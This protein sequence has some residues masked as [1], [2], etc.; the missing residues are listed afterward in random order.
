M[1]L[2]HFLCMCPCSTSIRAAS[3]FHTRPKTLVVEDVSPRCRPTATEDA[4][5]PAQHWLPTAI[6]QTRTVTCSRPR[7]PLQSMPSS[8]GAREL[9][10]GRGV[11][12]GETWRGA[13]PG[14]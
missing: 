12:W 6:P 11:A 2:S 14:T 8:V 13:S 9:L 4:A 5:H 1:R 10:N 3:V 7:S